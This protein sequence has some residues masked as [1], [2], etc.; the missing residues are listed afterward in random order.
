MGVYVYLL[1][2]FILVI[3]NGCQMLLFVGFKF[4][5]LKSIEDFPGHPVVESPH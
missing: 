3:Q 1:P 2:L 5:F 4:S